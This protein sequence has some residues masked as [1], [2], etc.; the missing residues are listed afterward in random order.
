MT[1]LRF[2]SSIEVLNTHLELINNK[3]PEIMIASDNYARKLPAIVPQNITSRIQSQSVTLY[4]LNN[5]KLFL[6]S[7]KITCLQS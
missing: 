5:T 3:A 1:L 2:K 4:T 7:A 6:L